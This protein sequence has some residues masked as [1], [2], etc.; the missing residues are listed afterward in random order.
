MSQKRFHI[1]GTSAQVPTRT[2]NQGGYFLRWDGQGFLFDPGE[3]SQRQLIFNNISSSSITKIFIT[4]FHGDHCLGL[5]GIVQRISLDRVQHDIELYFP[6]YGTPYVNNLLHAAIYHE[7]THIVLKPFISAGTIYEDVNISIKCKSLDHTVESY[8]YRIEE[9]DKR[10]LQPLKLAEIGVQGDAIKQLVKSGFIDVH[11]RRISIDDVSKL[12]KG[13]CCAFIMDTRECQSAI[14][15]AENSD[16]LLCESTYLSEESALAYE[17]GHLTAAQAASIALKAN[18][19]TLVLTH[20]SQ[21]YLSTEL[22]VQEA[23]KVHPHVLAANDGDIIEFP[24]N[25]RE[26]DS[27]A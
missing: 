24:S 1:L 15:L 18:A 16:I 11:D 7:E 20:Y 13:Q 10:T 2:R 26:I 5:A 27:D 19:K 22:Y 25:L 4:H 23:S 8:G 9:Q 12:K 6:E 3:G 14:D 17:Y 21:R